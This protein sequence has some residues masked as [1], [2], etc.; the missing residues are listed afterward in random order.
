MRS[1]LLQTLFAVHRGQRLDLGH[2]GELLARRRPPGRAGPGCTATPR[3][4]GATAVP[5]D[6]RG[7]LEPCAGTAHLGGARVEQRP[8]TSSSAQLADGGQ[9][10]PRERSHGYWLCSTIAQRCSASSSGTSSCAVEDVLVVVDRVV[11]V[12]VGSLKVSC[13]RLAQRLGDG[14][15]DRTAASWRRACG[16]RRRRTGSAKIRSS[17]ASSQCAGSVGVG[18]PH[19]G[20]LALA[21][22][23]RRH[24]RQEHVVAVRAARRASASAACRTSSSRSG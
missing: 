15:L 23:P 13:G 9:A 22:V 10:R 18:L 14:G 21:V 16:A 20:D 7:R 8:R 19:R 1:S 2:D 12:V 24:D 3:R 4:A 11:R 5:V 6:C 17:T